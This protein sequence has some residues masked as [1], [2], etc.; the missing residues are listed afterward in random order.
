M[1]AE[2]LRPPAMTRFF[3]AAWRRVI[4]RRLSEPAS[5]LKSWRRQERIR[6]NKIQQTPPVF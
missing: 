1:R 4:L 2:T 6:P 3:L 5:G